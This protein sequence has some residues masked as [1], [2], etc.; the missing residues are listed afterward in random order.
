MLEV[1]NE[2]LCIGIPL[3]WKYVPS[4]FFDSFVTMKKP[5]EY[6]YCRRKNG[7]L[8]G[9]RND[10][11]NVALSTGCSHVIMMDCDMVYHTDT[12]PRLLSH[13]LD[14]VGAMCY[15]RYPPFDE[16]LFKGRVNKYRLITDFNP[17]ELIEVDATGTGCL[18]FKTEVFMR[19][20]PPWFKFRQSKKGGVIGED[21]GFCS[22]LKNA[23]YKIFVDPTIPA[24]HLTDFLVE[25]EARRFYKN[26]EKIKNGGK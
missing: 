4:D 3:T 16:L 21:I 23:G 26:L 11:V 10:I 15:R 9:L 18:M 12:I 19:M 24:G 22:R 13:N 2:K 6:E 5:R 17:N 1:T 7:P 14:V 20:K 8:D 25:P